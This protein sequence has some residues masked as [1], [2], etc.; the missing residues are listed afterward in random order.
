MSSHVNPET[1]EETE[2]MDFVSVGAK[3]NATVLNVAENELK[4]DHEINS[5]SDI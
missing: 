5:T 3:T 2:T 4:I 1:S